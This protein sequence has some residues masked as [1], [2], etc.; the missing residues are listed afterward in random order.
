MFKRRKLLHSQHKLKTT[1]EVIKRLIQ[2]LHKII[3]SFC[4]VEM[5]AEV[6]TSVHGTSL[7]MAKSFSLF[8]QAFFTH[9]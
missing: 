8:S 7:P 3:L 1:L 4:A 2:K 5:A 9:V 6:G